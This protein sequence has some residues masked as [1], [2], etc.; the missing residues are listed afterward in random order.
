M[1]QSPSWEAGSQ[2]V[3]QSVKKSLSLPPILYGTQ[4]FITMFRRTRLT[5]PHPEPDGSSSHL[6]TLFLCDPFWYSHIYFWVFK[7]FPSGLPTKTLYTFVVS[8]MRA[9]WPIH[10]VLLDLIALITF[11]VTYKLWSSSL[12]SLPQPYAASSL[13]GP[14]ILLSTLFSNTLGLRKWTSWFILNLSFSRC[15]LTLYFW[16]PTFLRIFLRRFLKGFKMT[17]YPYY[18][19]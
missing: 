2:S 8:P 19:G 3:S 17:Q 6:P 7:V 4:R 1:E 15:K 12:C 11:G 10:L 16:R 14:N 13:L 18:F 5:G 9:T